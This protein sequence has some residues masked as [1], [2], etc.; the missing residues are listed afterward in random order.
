MKNDFTVR[1]CALTAANF[2][3]DEAASSYQICVV[4]G[5][6]LPGHGPSHEQVKPFH[7]ACFSAW[8]ITNGI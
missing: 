2:F 3:S 8:R 5:S 1:G 6:L 7:A 4:A